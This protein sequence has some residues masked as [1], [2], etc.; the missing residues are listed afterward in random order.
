[1][2]VQLA[3][4]YQIEAA[5]RL[6]KAP[7]GHKCRRLHGHTFKIELRLR[8]PVDPEAGWLIDY[9]DIDEA[10]EPIHNQLDHRYLNEIEGLEN[11]T[12]ELIARWIWQRLVDSLP[13]LS[14]VVVKE[15]C[16]STC[17]YRGD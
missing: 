13:N 12:S 11:P 9:A 14:A 5:H 2:D 16:Q 10:W 17:V 15:N 4:E 8:G 6:P 3:K 1:M 7:E